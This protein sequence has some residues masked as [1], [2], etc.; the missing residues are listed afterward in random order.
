MEIPDLVRQ[1]LGDETVESA[2]NLGD[3]DLVCFT[4]SRTLV[5]SGESLL[6]DESV[7]VYDHDVE[8][9]EVS[10]GRRN[11]VFELEYVDRTE[12]FKVANSRAE[13]VLERLLGGILETTGVTEPGESVESV[14]R[15]SELTLVVTDTRLVKRVGSYVWSSDFEEYPYS[16]V[17]GL[18]FEEGSVATQVVLSVAG[19]PQRIK[20]PSDDAPLVQQALTNALCGYYDVGSLEEL[21]A[22]LARDTPDDRDA[23]E[24][25]FSLDDTIAPLVDEGTES[26]PADATDEPDAADE[27]AVD[28]VRE[29]ATDEPEESSD[30][31][32]SRAA[33]RAAGT[34]TPQ[35]GE[36]PATSRGREP[37]VDPED[38]ET[39]QR[40]LSELRSAVDRQNQLLQDHQE[41]IQQLIEE[42]RRQ[43]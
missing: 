16:A 27:T 12:R 35:S 24:G 37:A 42:L 5:Y 29:G 13:A 23:D 32:G 3:E 36:E 8:R 30:D 38:I 43:L 4:P 15:F 33:R 34:A 39:M 17:T 26:G 21:N 1:R 10:D 28:T 6:S 9:L 40:E 20:A 7:E 22:T 18:E 25:D 31:A 14:F 41:T 19:R 2:V 11:T